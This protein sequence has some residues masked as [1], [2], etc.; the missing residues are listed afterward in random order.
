M[1]RR[2]EKRRARGPRFRHACD[3]L[4]Q[5]S[6]CATLF[7]PTQNAPA[8][9]IV[10]NVGMRYAFPTYA[11]L[12]RTPNCRK[13]R[14]ALRIS[15]LGRTPR[16]PRWRKCR[17]ALR[18]SDLRR[19]PRTPHCLVNPINVESRHYV[20][21]ALLLVC[22]RV[23][24]EAGDAKDQLFSPFRRSPRC[25]KPDESARHATVLFCMGRQ[26][27]RRMTASQNTGRAQ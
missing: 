8:L 25:C 13:C 22:R 2:S 27:Q 1:R 10:A 6:E 21:G 24:R 12:P 20:Y 5:M 9:L 26:G 11:E 23:K 14:N 17:N 15:D 16:T 19:T 3:A 18:F 7:R 4:A